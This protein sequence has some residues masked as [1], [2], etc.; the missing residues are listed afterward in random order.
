MRWLDG[1]TASM[2]MSLRKLREIVMDRE[3]C[4][5]KFM[6]SQRVGHDLAT[7]QQQSGGAHPPPESECMREKLLDYS[8]DNAFTLLHLVDIWPNKHSTLKIKFSQNFEGISLLP[9]YFQYCC[10]EIQHCFNS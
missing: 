6:G 10:C 3:A 2:D 7:E 8:S 1:I 4:V 9:S 5:L